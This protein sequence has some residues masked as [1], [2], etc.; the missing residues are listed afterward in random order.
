MEKKETIYAN[1]FVAKRTEKDPDFMVVRL[2]ISKD[3][4]IA[5]INKHANAEGWVNLEI[6]NG[7]EAGKFNVTLNTYQAPKKKYDM[8]KGT[9]WE[10]PF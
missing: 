8:N 6:K 4:A 5:F 9:K 7:R 3:D 10:S 2:S 1:G